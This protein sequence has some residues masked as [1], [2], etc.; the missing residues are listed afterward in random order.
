MWKKRSTKHKVVL[1]VVKVT[2]ESATSVVSGMLIQNSDNKILTCTHQLQQCW[3]WCYP[4][5]LQAQSKCGRGLHSGKCCLILRSPLFCR[6]SNHSLCNHRG[7]WYL[8]CLVRHSFS[9]TYKASNDIPQKWKFFPQMAFF[10]WYFADPAIINNTVAGMKSSMENFVLVEISHP[11][12][13]IS[14]KW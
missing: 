2:V 7:I 9:R 11:T 5:K 8:S 4:A 3:C 14:G 6:P 12:S 13:N 1:H 10:T